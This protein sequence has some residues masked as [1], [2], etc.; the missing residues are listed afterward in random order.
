MIWRQTVAMYAYCFHAERKA[1]LMQ[2]TSI[3]LTT[4]PVLL[5]MLMILATERPAYAAG[6]QVGSITRQQA[7]TT[8]LRNGQTIVLT[9]DSPIH[10]N[11]ELRTGLRSRLELTLKDGTTVTMGEN[12][13]MVVDR[14]VFDPDKSAGT[15]ILNSLKGPLRFISGRLGQLSEKRVEIRTRFATLD[16]RG[17]DFFAGVAQGPYGVL[18]FDG[19]VSVTNPAGNRVLKD[20]RTGLNLIAVD[21]APGEIGPWPQERI[22]ASL[23]AVA[24]D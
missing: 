21:G 22:N 2:S 15:A 20:A 23:A 11:D 19:E 5:I 16:I 9:V 13:V 6:V 12:G 8:A 17:T 3:N 4:I 24:F 18:L 1:D 10:E 7:D 14:Y